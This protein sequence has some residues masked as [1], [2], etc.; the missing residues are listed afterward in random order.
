MKKT[1]NKKV[2]VSLTEEEHTKLQAI[3]DKDRRHINQMAS[4]MIEDALVAKSAPNDI[5][6]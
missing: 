2:T 6:I 4:M 3:A 5:D 1:Y